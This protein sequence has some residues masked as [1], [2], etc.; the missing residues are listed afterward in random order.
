MDGIS[1]IWFQLYRAAPGPV[2]VITVLLIWNLFLKDFFQG[3]P[4]PEI[5]QSAGETEQP[6]LR[7]QEK[8]EEKNDVVTK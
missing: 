3:N 7:A 4:G 2:G 8:N 6:V 5:R 1:K